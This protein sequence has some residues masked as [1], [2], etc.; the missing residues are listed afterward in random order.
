MSN[1]DLEALE[2]R[3]DEEPAAKFTAI[4]YKDLRALIKRLR[5]AEAIVGAVE[6]IAHVRG[7]SDPT[8]RWLHAALS[9]T[10]K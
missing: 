2:R 5:K 10:K 1:F 4:S 7:S 9:G 3:L 8:G 6:E